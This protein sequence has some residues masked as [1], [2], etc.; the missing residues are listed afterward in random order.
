MDTDG[1]TKRRVD[2]E[3]QA[4]TPDRV[5]LWNSVRRNCTVRTKWDCIKVEFDGIDDAPDHPENPDPSGD[6]KEC[7]MI[8]FPTVN[9]AYF[10][11]KGAPIRAAQVREPGRGVGPVPEPSSSPTGP[12]QAIRG[13]PFFRSPPR[14]MG[15]RI[16]G[17]APGAAPLIPWPG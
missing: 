15:A 5:P 1:C 12:L 16:R 9:R 14:R 17:A 3:H 11:C 13:G 4:N 10:V 7:G 6:Y 2:K 8:S